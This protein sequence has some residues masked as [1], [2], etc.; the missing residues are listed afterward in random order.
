MKK[1]L[2]LVSVFLL[3]SAISAFAGLDVGSKV[4]PFAANDD[5]GLLWQLSEHL[6]KKNVVVY[7]YPAAMTGGCTKQACSY[8]DQSATMNEVDAV[9][10]G[11][12]GDSVSN[13][14]L[15]KQVNDLNFTLLSDPNGS[16]AKQFG[17]ATRGGNSIEREVDGIT[18]TL[19]RGITTMRW[20][21]IIGKDG[22]VF[23]K[24][25]KVQATEDTATVINEIKK[26]G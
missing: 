25:D 11:V 9:V 10:V 3:I 8:R 15:F 7:F 4:E 12:S 6:G 16:I 26:L 21:F 5:N 13:L 17:V 14:Q 22:R 23:Y 2:Q 1:S 18:H 19:S 24:N 20:T